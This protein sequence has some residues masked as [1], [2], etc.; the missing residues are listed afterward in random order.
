[1]QNASLAHHSTMVCKCGTVVVAQT[2]VARNASQS[3]AAAELRVV[4]IGRFLVVMFCVTPT[5]HVLKIVRIVKNKVK[6]NGRSFA[7]LFEEIF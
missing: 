2:A 1:M 6:E 7:L 3:E 5:S 4:V